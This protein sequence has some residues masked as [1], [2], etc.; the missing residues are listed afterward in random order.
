MCGPGS[1]LIIAKKQMLKVLFICRSSSLF[2]QAQGLSLLAGQTDEGELGEQHRHQVLPVL[3]VFMC[4]NFL[5]MFIMFLYVLLSMST[6]NYYHIRFF[7]AHDRAW[8]PLKDVYLY[9]FVFRLYIVLAWYCTSSLK[10][11]Y[12]FRFVIVLGR[13]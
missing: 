8:I 13:L 7:G 9:R 3:H 1:N 6:I 12:V 10:D 2:F 5:S 4:S 11:I